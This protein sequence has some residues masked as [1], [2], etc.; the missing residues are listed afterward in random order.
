LRFVSGFCHSV[1]ISGNSQSF[2]GLEASYTDKDARYLAL[3][4]RSL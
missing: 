1:E 4:F 2:V 3:G